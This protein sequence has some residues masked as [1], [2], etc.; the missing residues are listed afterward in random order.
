MKMKK[1]IIALF[2]ISITFNGYSQ[3]I[4][5][6]RE[7][8]SLIEQSVNE[9]ASEKIDPYLSED[10]TIA[11]QKG[12]FAKMILKQM[13]PQLNRT[14]TKSKELSN[15]KEN[16]LL[17]FK[18]LNT[19]KGAG[20]IEGTYV[21]NNKNKIVAIE[22]FKMSIQNGNDSNI[23]KDNSKAKEQ[24]KLSDSKK[25]TFNATDG[26]EISGIL[27]EANPNSPV[28]L[29]C[30]MANRNK[31][32]YI[33]IANKFNELG[34]TCLAID[35]RS[36][37]TNFGGINETFLKAKKKNLDTDY[38]SALIDIQAA[39]NFLHKKYNQKIIL[40]GS[41]YSSGL[42]LLEAKNNQKLKAVISLSP[43][44][45][46]GEK[47]NP[48]ATIVSKIKIPFLI[49]GSKSEAKILSDSFKDIKF[50]DDK[51]FFAP[52]VNGMHGSMSLLKSTDG[53]E[54]YW[55]AITNFLNTL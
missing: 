15:V 31:S 48:M 36:G 50:S 4:K 19:F 7:I 3:D 40:L 8:V 29:L 33:E 20:D 44:N 37:G 12:Q 28:I 10:F 46:Y 42:A 13:L 30:H 51:H 17:T 43:G 5:K 6:C 21:F 38:F 26:L 9:G 27:Y 16:E 34:Y 22:I 23:E 2:L 1:L 25:I 35:Q 24:E 52:K 14:I 54:T 49:T 47:V 41:S 32:E 53:N 11:K 39:I 55:K 18:Y 45:Y